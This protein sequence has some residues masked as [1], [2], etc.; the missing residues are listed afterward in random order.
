MKVCLPEEVTFL[1]GEITHTTTK[2]FCLTN[3]TFYSICVVV[4]VDGYIAVIQKMRIETK[5][6]TTGEILFT[7]ETRR[8]TTLCVLPVGVA[9]VARGSGI[10]DIYFPGAR[11]LGIHEVLSS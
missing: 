3:L 6:S 4:Y 8:A 7:I 11:G 1:E 2:H 10:H 9:M 5:H